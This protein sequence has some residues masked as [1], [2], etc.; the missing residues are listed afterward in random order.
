MSSRVDQQGARAAFD[1]WIASLPSTRA[2]SART[3]AGYDQIWTPWLRFL[4]GRRKRWDEARADDFGAFLDRLQTSRA[5]EPRRSSAA[6]HGSPAAGTDAVRTKRPNIKGKE[7]K[8]KKPASHVTLSRY[9]RVVREIYGIAVVDGAL[10]GNPACAAN[11]PS[12][13]EAAGS[14]AIY[15][16]FLRRLRKQLPK[17]DDVM[18]VR[19]RALLAVLAD[20]GLTTK[21]LIDLQP[22]GVSRSTAHDGFVLSITGE[23]EPQN[24][25]VYLGTDAS[26]EL[27]Q[28]LDA[29]GG[30]DN[31]V[32]HVFVSMRGKGKLAP[33]DVLNVVSTWLQDAAKRV[34]LPVVKHMGSNSLRTAVLI[35]WRDVDKL[36]TEELLARAGLAEAQALRRLPE[37]LPTPFA[38]P[39]IIEP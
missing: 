17:G 29:R 34:Q 33:T 35:W 19:D 3:I 20:V 5:P 12:K 25:E 13:G 1:A 7:P 10:D 36:S 27:A 9:W 23:R 38:K 37:P 28:W 8:L 26:R 11:R 31:P 22:G 18:T 39:P 21:E 6:L 15:P 14:V 30:L 4:A 2:L 32:D 16:Y 24:R